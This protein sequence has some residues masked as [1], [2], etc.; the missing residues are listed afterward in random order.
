MGPMHEEEARR[1]AELKTAP[2]NKSS[3]HYYGWNV[4]V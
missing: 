3:V 4:L 2:L 1:L